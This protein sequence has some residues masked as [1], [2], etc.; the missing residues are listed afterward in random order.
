MMLEEDD[1]TKFEKLFDKL[2]RD[3]KIDKHDLLKKLGNSSASHNV[4]KSSILMEERESSASNDM[5]LDEG[6]MAEDDS[7]MIIDEDEHIA[8]EA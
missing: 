3:G 5:L 8:S 6:I 1:L 7:Q 2:I 4:D